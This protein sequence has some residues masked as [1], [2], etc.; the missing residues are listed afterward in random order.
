[1]K[2]FVKNFLKCGFLGWRLEI[3][4]TALSSLQKRNWR[5]AGQTSL[6]MFPIYGSVCL[7]SPVFKLFKNTS[8]FFRGSIYALCLFIGEYLTGSLLDKYH[9]R[10]WSYSHSRWHIKGKIRLDYFPGWFVVGLLYER[11]L[12]D[13]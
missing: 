6:W 12:K 3:L 11:L 7:L 8:I 4:F 13:V 5:L 9:L 2:T 1:M 10:P